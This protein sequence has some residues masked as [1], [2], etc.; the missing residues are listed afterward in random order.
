MSQSSKLK[1]QCL[2]IGSL[3]HNNLEDAMKL[4]KKNFNQVPFWPQLTN[5][6]KKEDMLVQFSDEMSSFCSVS[7]S[8]FL[9]LVK[10]IQPDFAK[11]QITGPYTLYLA[12]GKD[13]TNNLIQKTIW[14]I[15]EIKSASNTTT[16]IIFIDEPSLSNLKSSPDIPAKMIKQIADVIKQNGGLCG[17]HCCGN[18]DWSIA[19]KTGIDIISFDAYSYLQTLG[20]EIKIFLRNGGKIAWGLVPTRNTEALK[21]S[22]SN[23]IIKIFENGVKYLTQKGINE[24][25]IIENSLITPACGAG[26]LSVELAEKAMDLTK[27]VSE[28]LKERYS[29]CLLN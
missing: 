3:P 20:D 1:L 18:C 13:I 14:Q 23:K 11:G 12:L 4:V 10:Q 5:L 2:A 27:Q 17:L 28:I 15:K 25:I 29:I 7:F 22:D 6:N 24:K 21:N 9:K 16:P 19:T 26:E 8:E